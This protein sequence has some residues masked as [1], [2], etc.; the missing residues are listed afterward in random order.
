[1]RAQRWRV[2]RAGL[3]R[4]YRDKRPLHIIVLG[5][6]LSLVTWAPIIYL[7]MY[8]SSISPGMYV[9]VGLLLM[10]GL[11][12]LRMTFGARRHELIFCAEGSP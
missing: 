12:G 11:I 9:R 10:G 7:A 3:R 1:M 4:G 6:L 2:E 5:V 8:W